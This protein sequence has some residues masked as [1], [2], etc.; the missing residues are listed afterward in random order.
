[1]KN[2]SPDNSREY[3]ATAPLVPL[4]VK[5]AIPAM[6]AQLVNLLYSI[7]DR[8]FI[9]HIAAYGTDALTGLGICVPMTML[10]SSFAGLAAFG[11]APLASMRL[12]AGER[13]E[14]QHVMRIAQTLMAAFAVALLVIGYAFMPQ[15]LGLFGA[16]ATTLPY[17]QGYLS[18]YMIGTFFVMINVGLSMFLLAQGNSAQMLIATCAGAVVHIALDALFIFGLGWG[19]EGAATSSIFSQGICAVMV[20]WYLRRPTSALRFE[21]RL[22]R[23]EWP[24][25]RRIFSIGSG[26][27][28][29]MI[30]ESL[31]VSVMNMTLQAYGGDLYVGALTILSSVLNLCMALMQGFTQGTQTIVSFCYGARHIERVRRAARY[32][33]VG[34]FCMSVVLVGIAFLFPAPFVHLFSNDEVLCTLAI[35]QTPVY[36]FGMIF[37]G[38]QLGLQSVFMGLG[39]G[40]CSLTV[41]FVR[42]IVLFIPLVLILPMFVGAEGVFLAEPISDLCSIAF[43]STL[44]AC[45]IPKML[46]RAEDEAAT[47]KNASDNAGAES[48][49]SAGE[50]H[51]AKGA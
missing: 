29:I 23:P 11:G 30:T 38:A 5:L 36:L 9:G 7:V 14:A 44:F 15:L 12:G 1:M 49:T 45:T 33:V 17:A 16:S 21:F 50:A 22:A 2:K 10:I 48:E 8:I 6:A 4:M 24:I 19:I 43:C 51:P 25:V 34:T 20:V 37:F 42:K 46:R 31:L 47:S 18:I 27:F 32:I 40:L 3:L 39:R 41:A 26:R 28:F 13:D 35:D